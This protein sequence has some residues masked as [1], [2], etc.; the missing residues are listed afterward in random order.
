MVWTFRICAALT[1]GLVLVS[2]VLLAG[3]VLGLAGKEAAI[4]GLILMAVAMVTGGL[5]GFQYP[6]VRDR[7]STPKSADGVHGRDESGT[8]AVRSGWSTVPMFIAGLVAVS[9][10]SAGIVYGL[11]IDGEVTTMRVAGLLIGTLLLTIA[12]WLHRRR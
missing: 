1:I 11:V 9:G 4:A 12:I 8:D 3:A 5:T 10:F 2:G 6:A 7:T